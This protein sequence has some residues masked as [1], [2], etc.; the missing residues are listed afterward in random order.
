MA[1]R[2]IE[3]NGIQLRYELAAGPQRTVV[4]VHEM[5][6]TLDSWDEVVD[7]LSRSA[8][9][10][11]Y[12][13]RGAG[14]SEKVPGPVTIEQF[15]ADLAGLLDALGIDRPVAVAGVA[16]GAA[17]VAAFAALYPTRVEAL[18]ML[19]PATGLKDDRRV[20]ALQRIETI[21]RDGVRAAFADIPLNA[22][23]RFAQLRLAADPIALAAT[24]RMLAD[25]D[26]DDLLRKIS[27]PVL[28][29][30]GI[31]DSARPPEQVADVADKIAGARLIGLDTTHYMAIE[32][33]KLVERTI[34]GFLA[35]CGFLQRGL[36]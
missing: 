6:G 28:V 3:A 24:W 26:M 23:Q 4:L 7:P 19:A 8:T 34:V 15:A 12:D 21:E 29:A 32:T 36:V 11:R 18:L 16:V 31:R 33:P 2:W 14:L 25:L 22:P 35:E 1:T 9:V 30:A 5:G 27:C 13:Q 10:L 20:A 17:V